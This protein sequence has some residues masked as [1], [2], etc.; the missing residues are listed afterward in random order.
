MS[1][2][3][4]QSSS[5]A[6]ASTHILKRAFAHFSARRIIA[7]KQYSSIATIPAPAPT[8]SAATASGRKGRERERRPVF[9]TWLCY[10]ETER[11]TERRTDGPGE[12]PPHGHDDGGDV[13]SGSGRRA[14][15]RRTVSRNT[16]VA[17]PPYVHAIVLVLSGHS[18]HRARL[19]GKRDVRFPREHSRP[20]TDGAGLSNQTSPVTIGH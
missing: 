3:E 1:F 11:H 8:K 6:P 9:H 17:R 4:R 12:S 10:V 16:H 20:M 14:C 5:V 19:F 18:C 15:S 7:G 13:F 2:N